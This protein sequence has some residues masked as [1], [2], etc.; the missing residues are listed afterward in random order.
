MNLVSNVA[1]V[2]GADYDLNLNGKGVDGEWITINNK[3]KLKN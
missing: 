2:T 1:E 3:K